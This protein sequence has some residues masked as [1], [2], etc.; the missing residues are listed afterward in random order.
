MLEPEISI[1]NESFKDEE[2]KMGFLK[3]CIAIIH[4]Y[5]MEMS[6]GHYKPDPSRIFDE[7]EVKYPNI[8]FCMSDIEYLYNE[9]VYLD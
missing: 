9:L 4:N 2:S 3:G 8:D 1:T 7:L 5:L 6:W